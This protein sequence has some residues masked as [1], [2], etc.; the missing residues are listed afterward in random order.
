MPNRLS[1]PFAALLLGSAACAPAARHAEPHAASEARFIKAIDGF[2]GPEG[3]KYD[4]AQDVWFVSNLLGYG[5]V[6]DGAG[7]IVRIP[8][9]ALGPPT[10]LVQGGVNGATLDAPKGM[11]LQGDTLWVAD[12]DVLRGFDRRT[13]APRGSIDLRPQHAVLLNDVTVGHD[14]SLYATDSGILMTKEGVLHPGGDRIFRIGAG[15]HVEVV[16]AGGVLGRPN[17]IVPDPGGNGVMVVSFDPFH[18]QLYRL[19]SQG[20]RAS[21]TPLG[22]GKGKFDGV[23]VAP[24][25]GFVVSCWNDSSIH[26]MDRGR[27]LR[28]I[29]G[30][31][32]PADIAVDTRRN[33]IAIPQVVRGR[34]EF[35]QLPG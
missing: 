25:G 32:Q 31:S 2:Y 27:D 23:D 20:A 28:I 18:S 24:R 14:G 9:G 1:R 29:G 35:W 13:G 12:I 15:H 8:A 7:Y 30:L 16:A 26:L 6:K 11:A 4:S 21:I 19:T 10:L 5:S 33:R 17:G 34:V 3:V 22:H